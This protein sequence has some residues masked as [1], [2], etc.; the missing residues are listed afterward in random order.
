VI[1]AETHAKRSP[2]E[3]QKFFEI[4]SGIPMLPSR[5]SGPQNETLKALE[6]AA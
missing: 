3:A 6:I 2:Q 4:V 1:E 5:I